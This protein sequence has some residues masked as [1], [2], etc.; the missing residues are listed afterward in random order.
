MSAVSAVSI[1]GS[2]WRGTGTKWPAVLER[3]VAS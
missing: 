2:G 1:S 3:K